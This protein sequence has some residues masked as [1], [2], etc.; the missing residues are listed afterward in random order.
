MGVSESGVKVGRGVGVSVGVGDTYQ[1]GV[2]ETVRVGGVIGEGVI[3]ASG[4]YSSSMADCQSIPAFEDASLETTA[5]FSR[6]SGSIRRAMPFFGEW[7]SA[8]KEP[9]GSSRVPSVAG[10]HRSES[11]SFFQP[12]TKKPALKRVFLWHLTSFWPQ[13]QRTS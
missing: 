6:L 4:G 2:G 13:L 10:T 5:V 12:A 9:N 7:Q 11:S 3:S 8:M 1:R